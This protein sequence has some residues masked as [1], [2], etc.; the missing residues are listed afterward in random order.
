MRTV[1]SMKANHPNRHGMPGRDWDTDIEGAAGEMVVAKAFNLYW[2]C[3]VN[4]FKNPDLPNRIQVRTTHQQSL[5]VRSDD[6]DGDRFV[7]VQG[8]SPEFRVAGWLSGVEAKR[9]CWRR[10]PN[11]R[12]A[13]WFVPADALHPPETL[14]RS[15]AP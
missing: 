4:T 13:A 3:S 5:I 7:M 15:I 9:D 12:P 14:M 10:A 11:G 2:D 6:A 1:S 8:R